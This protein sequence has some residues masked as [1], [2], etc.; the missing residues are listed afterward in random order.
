[1]YSQFQMNFGSL[2]QLWM[3]AGEGDD[4]GLLI[5]YTCT[6]LVKPW[7]DMLNMVTHQIGMG[8]R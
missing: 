6:L 8:L 2:I 1:M 3:R 4:L 5:Q 7:L